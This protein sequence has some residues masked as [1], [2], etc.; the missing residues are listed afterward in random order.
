M[1]VQLCVMEPTFDDEFQLSG[2]VE[3]LQSELKIAGHPVD[4]FFEKQFRQRVDSKSLPERIKIYQMRKD[5]L[6]RLVD[7]LPATS[8]EPAGSPAF[9]EPKLRLPPDDN[10]RKRKLRSPPDDIKGQSP[11]VAIDRKREREA[12]D[13]PAHSR[14]KQRPCFAYAAEQESAPPLMAKIHVAFAH[15]CVK[16]LQERL[17]LTLQQRY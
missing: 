6:Q 5:Q 10:E 14:T 15:A 11:P 16:R 3:F 7:N 9:G 1:P 8:R 13:A 2:E 17:T 4:E 12:G